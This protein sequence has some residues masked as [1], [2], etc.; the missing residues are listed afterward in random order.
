MIY[1]VFQIERVEINEIKMPDEVQKGY[2]DKAIEA[3]KKPELKP[4]AEN[5]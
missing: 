5:Q 4:T 2:I 3:I 1:Y